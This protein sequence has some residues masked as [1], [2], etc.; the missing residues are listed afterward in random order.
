[1]HYK[2]SD[3][4]VSGVIPF[5]AGGQF[6]RFL[7]L[8]MVLLL[9]A[10][11]GGSGGGGGGGGAVTQCTLTEE[12]L[13]NLTPA[14][15]PSL[16]K[17]CEGIAFFD[18]PSI[19]GVF[20]LGTET[21]DLGNLKLYVHGVKQDGSPMILADFEQAAVSVGG[22]PVIRPDD[23]DVLPVA[24]GNILSMALLADYSLSITDSDLSGMGD[25]YD[26]V[27]D[28]T[29]AGFEAET[30]NF[31]SEPGASPTPV[32]ITVKPNPFP[33]WTSNLPALQAANNLDLDQDRNNTTLYDAMGTG[34]MGPIDLGDRYNPDTD[35]MGL[36]ERNGPLVVHNRP[37]TLLM[38]QTDGQDNASLSLGLNDIVA[39]LD[40]CHTTAIMLGTFR[41]EVDA[42]VLEELAGTRGAAV[43][44]L[45]T[46][47]LEAAIIPYAESLSNM[48]VFTLL[49]HTDFLNLPPDGSVRIEVDGLEANAV[50][51]FDIDGNCQRI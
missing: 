5:S 21:D 32:A 27:L 4:E 50:T 46:N 3:Y 20:I 34:L 19:T 9:A 22:V 29:P 17:A 39:L 48:V 24:N 51:P 30:I 38:V 12:E 7:T 35:D 6:M 44:A 10:C 33:Y 31:S 18:I 41:S 45:N 13:D 28:G 26:I 2:W 36:V 25:L 23:W 16:P 42:Q 40:R 14:D 47:F 49:P 8:I 37:A 1:M 43:N 15:V 11:G